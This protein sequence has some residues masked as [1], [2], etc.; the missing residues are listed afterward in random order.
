MKFP[1]LTKLIAVAGLAFATVS[2]VFADFKTDA[3]K[4]LTD[5]APSVVGIRGLLK[6]NASMNGQPSGG[7]D[8]PMASNGV[9]VADGLIAVAYRTLKPDLASAQAQRPGLTIEAEI[10]EIKIVTADG[11]EYDAKL[12]LHDEDLGVAFVAVDPKAENAANFKIKAIDISKDASVQHLDDLVGIG[13]MSEKLRSV[14]RANI[15]SVSA[16]V[17]RPR[18]IYICQGLSM[19]T[20]VFN[21]TGEFIGLTVSIKSTGTTPVV[22][23]AKYIRKVLD[24]AK[25]KQTELTK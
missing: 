1:Q 8:R 17:N 19:S 11:E 10:S 15:G 24:Q 13:R 6:I 12:V 16:I 5:H 18:K 21:S 2:P 3:R 9:V 22:I 25:V 4:V 23:A 7:Q 20:P 14:A